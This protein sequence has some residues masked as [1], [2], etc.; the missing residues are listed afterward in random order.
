M[1]APPGVPR[2]CL[3]LSAIIPADMLKPESQQRIFWVDGEAL[4]NAW[5][6]NDSRVEIET[7]Y[8][9]IFEECWVTT[10]LM[11]TPRPINSCPK[12]R[13][14]ICGQFHKS[15]PPNQHLKQTKHSSGVSSSYTVV[16]HK[17]NYQWHLPS[18]WAESLDPTL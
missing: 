10:R 6:G 18:A 14:A 11:P 15:L 8:C 4:D 13:L 17:F 16:L 9:S 2:P 12:N 1:S 3:E 5:Q 7:C